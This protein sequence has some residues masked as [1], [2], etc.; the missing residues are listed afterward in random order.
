M[1]T[2]K[3]ETA[4]VK[5]G[6]IWF[7]MRSRISKTALLALLTVLPGLEQSFAQSG[8]NPSVDYTV[9]NFA[10][11]P[12]LRKF[13]DS[14][15]GLGPTQTNNLGQYL[16]VA[17]PDT[18]AYPGS[19][20]YEIALVEYR[21]QMHSDLPPV[22]GAK[23]SP[24]AT[25][26]TKLRG[27][28]QEVNGVAVGVPHYLGP[29]IVATAGR[30]TRIKFTNRLPTG[31]KGDLF[32][33]T[34][35]TIMGAGDGPVQIG[36][37]AN[38]M[39]M[40]EQYTQ[41][42]ATLHLH[43][44]VNPWISDGMPH[45]WTAPAGETTSYKK[46]V[47]AGNVSDMG[48]PTNGSLTFYWPNQNSGRLM[49]YHDHSMGITRLNVYGGE[50]AGYLVSDPPGTGEWTLP[51]PTNTIPL[52]I[53]D[54]TFVCDATTLT[55]TNSI[56]YTA[57]TDPLWDSSKWGGGGNLWY[58]HVYVPNQDPY[59]D[60]GAN[61]LGRWDY[62]PWFWPVFPVTEPYPPAL[63]AVPEAFMDTPVINGTAYPYVNVEPKAY[64]LR[65]LNVC[66][67]RMLNLQMYVADPA[68][69]T[70]ASGQTFTNTEVRMI[71]AVPGT[72]IPSWYPTMDNRDGGVPDPLL[73]G[74]RMVQIGTEGG[75]LPSPVVITNTPVG[76]DYNRRN[77]VVLN[78]LERSLFMAP[79]ERA[80]IIVDFSR[81][82]G[83]TIILYN[84]APAPVPAF[85]PR[86]D[87]YTD[88]P[89]YSITGDDYQG[90][91]PSTPAGYGPN[92]R[93][94]MQFRVANS[95]PGPDYMT[96]Q[97]PLLRTA[98]PVAFTNTQPQIIVQ[99]AAY[100]P[101]YGTNY[102]N[103]YSRI[104]DTSLALK[105]QIL[106]SVTVTAGGSGYSKGATVSL[107]GGG[108]TG[109][110]VTATVSGKGVVQ[111]INVVNAGQ[112]Y[113]HA[114]TVLITGVGGQG[115][116]ATATAALTGEMAMQPKTIQELFDDYGRMNAT[117]GVEL[118]FTTS[119]IQ[120]TIPLGYMD[121]VT[122]IFNDGETQLWKVTHNGVD[123]HGIHFHLVN[124]QVVNR[125]G[126]DGMIRPPDPNELGWKD[127]VRMNPL[128]DV[129]VALKAVTPTLPFPLPDSIRP[130]A[131][132]LPLGSTMGFMGVD[133]LTGNPMAVSNVVANF[134]W[135]YMWHCHLLGHEEN[136]MMRAIVVKVPPPAPSNLVASALT[137]TPRVSLTWQDKSL[138]ENGFT[139]QRASNAAFT[140]GLVTFT[141]GQ[142]VTNYTDTSVA[143]LTFYYY[144]VMAT[145]VNGNSAYT[146]V[147]TVTTL[148]S[149]P[150][151]PTNLQMT[152]RTATTITIAWNDNSKNELGF[153]VERS[154][155]GGATWTRIAQTATNVSNYQNT[156]LTTKTTYLYRV[157][158][159][160]ASGVS[161][162]SNVKSITT[163]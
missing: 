9:P 19:D 16:P 70:N 101:A 28:V 89:D 39:P 159:F 115:T 51:I 138:N 135:E 116:G 66:G 50:A 67:E 45:Q 59:D 158:A 153:Y 12:P 148:A 76:Y 91:A 120:T 81:F 147:A 132:H 83:K 94:I 77:V 22:V 136:D 79:A 114:P 108:G 142:N 26:G 10:Y 85:D 43:G 8:P 29:V 144:R 34:D 129:I 73:E 130:L 49:F 38:G 123:T 23:T 84:D 57:A 131:P 24:T 106:G 156:G 95:T 125:V 21:E 104:Q 163:L 55:A 160:N 126:W 11:S 121:P 20:Y 56:R 36:K 161:G 54:K 98:L 52:I 72:N 90:G 64:R 145:S 2:R 46:G 151:A 44:G 13:V 122:E 30:P 112:G 7:F 35:T 139:I 15:P 140:Q 96:T 58:P 6:R 103:V 127:T 31:S 143:A 102:V 149:P 93:T 154:T 141:V 60:S 1:N 88:D 155:D 63:S 62:G 109:A 157:Q 150:A 27:Y 133:P 18:T 5:A 111:A 124:V 128:E 107:F 74:P 137:G 162:Y 86:Y 25:G 17:T 113:T 3:D 37:D 4:R 134:G 42:R 110:V 78:V 97:L 41:N 105:P 99:Q 87:F 61:P 68:V 117:L 100:G 48:S 119:L 80:D 14:L 53:Q 118:P 69:Y 65:I 33:P 82:A 146:S 40:Y 152:K 75:L 71:S 32:L 47:S 92:T